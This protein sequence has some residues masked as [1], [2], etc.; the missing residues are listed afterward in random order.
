[1]R[2][3]PDPVLRVLRHI[4]REEDLGVS[5]SSGEVVCTEVLTLVLGM[6]LATDAV[7]RGLH[8]YF[9]NFFDQTLNKVWL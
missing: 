6:G 2:I 7:E 5:E 3:S 4:L 9:G 1:M 8:A